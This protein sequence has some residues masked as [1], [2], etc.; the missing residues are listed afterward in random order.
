MWQWSSWDH[1]IQDFDSTKLNYGIVKNHPE[2]LNINAGRKF[3]GDVAQDWQHINSVKYNPIYDQILLSCRQFNEIFIIDHSTTIV[4]AAAHK[5]G[6][7]GKGGDL[8]YRWGNNASYKR[9]N[10]DEQKLFVQH[11]A[12]WIPKG[13]PY[14]GKVMIFNNQRKEFGLVFSSVDI[15]TLPQDSIGNFILK[16]DSTF[17]PDTLDWSY[18]S[19]SNFYS[20]VMSNGQMLKS[21]HV[22]VNEG[23]PGRIF[24][25]DEHKNTIWQYINPVGKDNKVFTQGSN[26]LNNFVYKAEIIYPDHP[27]LVNRILIPGNP[28]E[29][30]PLPI[31]S[32]CENITGINNHTMGKILV[33][34]NPF[35]E[36]LKFKTE[37]N[38]SNVVIE[39]FDIY[40]RLI[41]NKQ[42]ALLVGETDILKLEIPTGMY[43]LSI[44]DQINGKIF[45]VNKIF[46]A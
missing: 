23:E 46:K 11:N 18:Y 10:E 29:K 21:G 34:P 13:Y 15:I 36:F 30:K 7:Y 42:I 22:L 1:L 28:I 24:E 41:Y 35:N 2:L 37:K 6:R 12:Y 38:L 3:G 32:I 43:F 19:R 5:G 9:G 33:S 14:E 27:G 26:P 4:E 8:L 16:S 39:I 20:N 45:Y 31:P 25:I 17:G 40:G 44:K